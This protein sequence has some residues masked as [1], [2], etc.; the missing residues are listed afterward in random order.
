VGGKL[1][2][3]ATALAAFLERTGVIKPMPESTV[4]PPVMTPEADL[5]GIRET[6]ALIDDAMCFVETYGLKHSITLK[7]K[8]ELLAHISELRLKALNA[9]AADATN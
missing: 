4:P 1:V 2:D 5:D 3:P 9:E 7:A 6:R 8:A